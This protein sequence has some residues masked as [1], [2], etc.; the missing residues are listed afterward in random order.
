GRLPG[1]GGDQLDR[2]LLPTVRRGGRLPSGPGPLPD[3]LP[4]LPDRGSDRQRAGLRGPGGRA[5]RGGGGPAGG[6]PI[7]A[8]G[9]PSAPDASWYAIYVA[10]VGFVE[11]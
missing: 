1:R 8:F 4:L 7:T 9:I 2:P 6:E 3:L 10:A 11:G 5:N